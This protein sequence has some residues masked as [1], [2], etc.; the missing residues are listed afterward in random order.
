MNQNNRIIVFDID[1]TL[2]DT[3]IGIVKAFNYVLNHYGINGIAN[4]LEDSIIGPPIY[5][6]FVKL[7]CFTDKMATEATELY[8]KVYIN[9]Y[10]SETTMYCGANRLLYRL[11]ENGCFLGIA[12]MKTRP[13]VDKLL[14]L[15][16]FNSLFDVIQTAK[17]DGSVSKSAMLN[18]AKVYCSSHDENT[19]CYMVGDTIGDY[20]AAM[21]SGYDFIAADY[22][23]G[24]ID[25]LMC[26]HI[27]SIEELYDKLF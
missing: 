2:F 7:F 26:K 4:E 23:Y 9:K 15:Y 1:G 5:E 11:I 20:Q 10:L 14:S 8:R 18:S 25:N 17:E 6:S 3:K 13:Q 16:G 24:A 21:D 19:E 27:S 12:T 22:G